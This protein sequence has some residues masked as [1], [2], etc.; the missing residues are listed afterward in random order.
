MDLPLIDD[1]VVFENVEMTVLSSGKARM[2][3]ENAYTRSDAKAF[4]HGVVSNWNYTVFLGD[5]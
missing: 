3:A 2:I 5:S 4:E 1:P